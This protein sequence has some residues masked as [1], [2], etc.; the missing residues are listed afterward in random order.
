MSLVTLTVGISA[1]G[2]STWAREESKRTG[3]VIVCR[4]DIRISQGLKHGQNEELVTKL[5]HGHIEIALKSGFDVIVA[6]TNL[7]PK[8]RNQLV[9]LAHRLGADVAI[10]VFPIDYVTALARDTNREASVGA[11]VLSR[12]LSQFNSNTPKDELLPV[13][14]FA[15]Y[16]RPNPVAS[17]KKAAYIFDLDG[18]VAKMVDRDPY[19]YMSAG[20]DEPIVSVLETA[21]ALQQAGYWII[22]A[23]GR[24]E[25]SRH[26]VYKWMDRH[27]F[28]SDYTL[29]MRKDGDKRPDWI[30]KNELYDERI[31]P[32]YDVV[33]VFDDRDQVVHHLRRRGFTVFQVAEGRF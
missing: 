3:A 30:V 1:S 13:R 21:H 22:F 32:Y 31:I 11:S 15:P 27:S 24:E 12:Q 29:V 14:T 33:G 17:D 2:K 8:F 28:L 23:S 9:K 10:K 4:D 26:V 7:I 25:S 16:V 18:T 20:S 5:S 19:D 6:D